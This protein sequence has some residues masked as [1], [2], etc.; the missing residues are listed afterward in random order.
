MD[1]RNPLTW[2]A[3]A[4]P[5]VVVTAAFS[6]GIS[7]FVG[8]SPRETPVSASSADV[9]FSSGP[10]YAPGTD[11]MA[12]GASQ[13]GSSIEM[14]R[15]ANQDYAS[16]TAKAAPRVRSAFKPKNKRELQEFMRQVHHAIKYDS[17]PEA[18]GAGE[19]FSSGNRTI[20][21]PVAR[22][23]Q[24]QAAAGSGQALPRLQSAAGDKQLVAGAAPSF[25]SGFS[26]AGAAP[27]VHGG[28]AARQQQEANRAAESSASG[29]GSAA[30][31]GGGNGGGGTGLNSEAYGSHRAESSP[32]AAASIKQA[33]TEQK[34]PPAPVAYVW[35][36]TID[37]GNLYTY[38]TAAR[39][40]IVMNIGDAPLVLGGI[41][42]IDDDTPFY[43]E[44]NKCASATL[45]P[46][47]SCTFNLRFSPRAAKEYVTVFE[48]PSN[49]EGAFYYQSYMEVK[50]NSKYSPWTSWWNSH[51][52]GTNYGRGNKID[53]GMVPEGY[54]MSEVLRVT[55]TGSSD[56]YAVKLDAAKLPA[57]FR[58][59][60]DACTGSN[61]P[62]GQSCTL[63]VT[64]SPTEAVNKKFS[65]SY[66]GQYL[67]L[68]SDTGAKVYSPRPHFPPLLMDSPV[69]ANPNGE[70]TV[71]ASNDEY[72]HRQEAVLGVPVTGL[73]CAPFP[74]AGLTRLQHYYY[75]R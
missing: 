18:P 16:E 64:F 47:K 21:N 3:A 45:A 44:N 72:Y 51:W 35:P 38:E 11:P 50:G 61:L 41:A 1:G 52:G 9:K 49:D 7:Y 20:V 59:T 55:N 26:G 57:S 10:N 8:G 62:A 39:Q 60:G 65:S 48:V 30:R 53:F 17:A 54:S 46:G 28:S 34:P 4:V 74:A 22:P 15:K 14:F 19:R 27:A 66:Y 70:L 31:G 40:I 32:P 69:E 67:A 58:V 36:R 63:T 71:L 5:L 12:R 73:S 37:F 42:N 29:G 68:N 23:G 24:P 13:G 43:L 56:W 25:A 75:F 6:V 2:K 33:T